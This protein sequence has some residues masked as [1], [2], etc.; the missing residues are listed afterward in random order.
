MS[1]RRATTTDLDAMVALIESHRDKLQQ[2]QPVFWRRV[3]N[4]AELTHQYFQHLLKQERVLALVSETDLKVVGFLFGLVID[5]PPVFDPGGKTCL[6]DDFAV[7]SDELWATAGEEM[8]VYTRIWAKE[9]GAAQTV[10][11]TPMAY[12]EKL[13]FLKGRQMIPS[14]SWWVEQL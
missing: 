4:S 13:G 5:A 12:D 8:L 3:E 2:W 1:V 14:A 11:I 6:V 9:Q 10:V 7:A